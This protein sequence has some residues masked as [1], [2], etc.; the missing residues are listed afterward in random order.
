[1]GAEGLRALGYAE[2]DVEEA[3]GDI[4]KR[5]NE[6]LSEQVQGDVMSGRDRLHLQLIP[7]PLTGPPVSK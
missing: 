6:R 7:E 3:T 1:M 4:R 5:D 2:V